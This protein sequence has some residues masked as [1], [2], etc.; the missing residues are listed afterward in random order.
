VL[1]EKEIKEGMDRQFEASA[2]LPRFARFYT[3][4]VL[5]LFV[6]GCG[7]SNSGSA[8][9]GLIRRGKLILTGSSTMAPMIAALGHEF[10]KTRPGLRVEVQTGGTARGITDIRNKIA[11]FAMVSRELKPAEQNLKSRVVAQDGVVMILHKENPVTQLSEDQIRRIYTGAIRNWKEVGGK[12]AP[13]T[14]LNKAEGYSTLELFLHHFHL[15]GNEI[16]A[17]V[18]TGDNLQGIRTLE[19][20]PNAIDYVSIGTA[21]FE[22]RSGR[23]IKLLPLNG[24]APTFDNV[25]NGTY[26]LRRPLMV[27]ALQE[28]KGIAAEFLNF[29][30]SEAAEAKIREYLFIPQKH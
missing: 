17:H 15:K 25:Q 24:V 10:E 30:T 11:D 3:V 2:V 9:D 18:I 16:K 8:D 20:N 22:A 29:I 6:S 26:P 21:D 4:L 1:A 19:G 7:R 28:P 5:F 13:I 23:P 12:D 14:V 27:A